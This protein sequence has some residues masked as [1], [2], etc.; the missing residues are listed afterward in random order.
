MLISELIDELQAHLKGY[1]DLEVMVT[2][3]DYHIKQSP[4][5][6][7]APRIETDDKPILIID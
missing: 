2:G 4:T 6:I 1:G 3:S 7:V 5:V